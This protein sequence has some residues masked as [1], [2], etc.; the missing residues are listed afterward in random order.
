M[1]YYGHALNIG[2]DS[3]GPRLK[4]RVIYFKLMSDS[5]TFVDDV[6]SFGVSTGLSILPIQLRPY[7]VRVTPAGHNLL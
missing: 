2:G 3:F 4:S 5:V 6:L 7:Q 1:D